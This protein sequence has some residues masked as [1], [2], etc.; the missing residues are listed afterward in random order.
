MPPILPG[1]LNTSLPE[2]G[3]LGAVI[4]V[5]LGVDVDVDVD[6]GG[7]GGIDAGISNH[8]CR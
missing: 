3:E 4:D 8:S 5:D 1:L 6:E 2:P 7:G